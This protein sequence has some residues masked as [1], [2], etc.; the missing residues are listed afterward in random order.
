M[1]TS[2]SP[3]VLVRNARKQSGL[4]QAELA[5]RAGV[6]QSVIARLERSG[7]NPTLDTLERLLDAAGYEL[8]L[9]ANARRRPAVDTS[10][11]TE[12]LGWSPAERLAAHTAAHRN[13]G[14]LRRSARRSKHEVR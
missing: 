11:L 9:R 6:T 14:A 1:L 7:A 2:M 12:R 13:L 4:T 5:E 3:S 10:Q 8:E